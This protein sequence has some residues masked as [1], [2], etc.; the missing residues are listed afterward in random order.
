MYRGASKPRAHLQLSF[1]KR[2]ENPSKPHPKHVESQEAPGLLTPGTACRTLLVRAANSGASNV[3][4]KSP[5]QQH[6]LVVPSHKGH[7]GTGG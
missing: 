2:S 6:L 4:G 5:E 3:R 1:T 7:Q